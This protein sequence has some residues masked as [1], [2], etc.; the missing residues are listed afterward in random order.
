MAPGRSLPARIGETTAIGLLRAVAIGTTLVGAAAVVA[1]LVPALW[2]IGDRAAAIA[3]AGLRLGLTALVGGVA[4]RYLCRSPTGRL[5]HERGREAEEQLSGGWLLAFAITLVAVPVWL[6]AALEPLAAL[7]SD[8]IALVV[9][10]QLWPDLRGA[11][12]FSGL[13]VIPLAAMFAVPCLETVTA[14]WFGVS[15]LLLLL[16]VVL[17]SPR[18]PRAFLA[19]VVLQATLVAA[20]VFGHEAAA[21]VTAAVRDLVRDTGDAAFAAEQARALDAVGRYD[22]VLAA[23]LRTLGWALVASLVW[24]PAFVSS[25]RASSRSPAITPPPRVDPLRGVLTGSPH[26]GHEAA[27][28]ERYYAD[29]AERLDPGG[30]RSGR[31]IVMLAAAVAGLV[32]L[33]WL[34]SAVTGAPAP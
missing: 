34:V 25:A 20:S 32:A 30:A 24:I 7:W 5:P 17:R 29:A 2:P 8:M 6:V 12:Q 19:C 13:I 22:V 26:P 31:G 33:A 10:H 4:T 15:A 28:R 3:R 14:G 1:A 11:Q 16:L 23:S 18:L 9:D 21:H 27:D